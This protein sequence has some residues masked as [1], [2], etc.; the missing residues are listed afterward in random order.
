[1]ENTFLHKN[2]KGKF[3]QLLQKRIEKVIP[4]RR[5]TAEETMRLKKLEAIAHKLRCGDN[6]QNRQ[7]QTWL[8]EEYDNRIFCLLY[9]EKCL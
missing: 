2:V 6:I 7:L 5:L 9:E 8:C 3:R 1:M 4:R